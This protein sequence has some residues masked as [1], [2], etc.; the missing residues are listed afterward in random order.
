MVTC[1]TPVQDEGT[2]SF[3][4]ARPS[5]AYGDA[6]AEPVAET[7]TVGSPIDVQVT[8]HA[9]LV[10]TS[11]ADLVATEAGEPIDFETDVAFEAEDAVMFEAAF[12]ETAPDTV[13]GP[14]ASEAAVPAPDGE[15]VAPDPLDVAPTPDAP[16][17]DVIDP[18]APVAVTEDRVLLQFAATVPHD[19]AELQRI[20]ADNQW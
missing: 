12:D 17:V 7:S 8:I 13:S 19:L 5:E 10:T 4:D 11:P 2:A 20:A 6:I 1:P 9:D 14:A 15:A 18:P 16:A 3:F